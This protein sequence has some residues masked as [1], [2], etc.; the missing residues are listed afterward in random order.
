[1]SRKSAPSRSFP[2]WMNCGY[3]GSRAIFSLL[4]SQYTKTMREWERQPHGVKLRIRTRI[5]GPHELKHA[6][7]WVLVQLS[8]MGVRVR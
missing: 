1:M 8:E 5:D 3:A 7:A 2:S 4:R 6:D